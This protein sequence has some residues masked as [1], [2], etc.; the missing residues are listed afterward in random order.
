MIPLETPAGTDIV[1][2]EDHTHVCTPTL[3]IVKGR[4]YTLLRWEMGKLYGN[5]MPGILVDEGH[6]G[7][8]AGMGPDVPLLWDRSLFRLPHYGKSVEEFFCKVK[9]PA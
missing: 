9:E 8:V 6:K 3:K 5:N 4:V 7:F 1:A 2:I